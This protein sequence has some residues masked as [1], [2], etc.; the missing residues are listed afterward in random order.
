[1]LEAIRDLDQDKTS[2][3]AKK[4]RFRIK[5][6]IGAY[7]LTAASEEECDSWVHRTLP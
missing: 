4:K 7:I 5:T 1:M 6:A 3:D 2:G